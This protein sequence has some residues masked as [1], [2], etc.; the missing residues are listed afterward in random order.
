LKKVYNQ[1]Y[2]YYSNIEHHNIFFGKHYVDAEN[3]EPKENIEGFE[4]LPHVKSSVALY[5]F[6]I[7]FIEI[8][9]VFNYEFQLKWGEKLSEMRKVHEEEYDLLKE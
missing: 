6:R 4:K 1:V 3:C 8:L 2:G 5:L 7:I 9:G